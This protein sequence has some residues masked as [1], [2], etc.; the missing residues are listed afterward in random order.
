MGKPNFAWTPLPK[1]KL[2]LSNQALELLYGGSA[3]GGKLL[4]LDTPLATPTGWTAIGDVS[5]G[6]EILD[7]NGGF[8]MD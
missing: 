4:A 1:Q 7:V 8:I 2:A 3:G 6:A 5:V